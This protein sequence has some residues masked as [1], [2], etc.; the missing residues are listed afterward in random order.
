MEE[1]GYD[2]SHLI[3]GTIIGE[4]KY[5]NLVIEKGDQYFYM[6]AGWDGDMFWWECGKV[7]P[8]LKSS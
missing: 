4:D 1:R 5:G 7:K 3:G 8:E 2:L 6:A